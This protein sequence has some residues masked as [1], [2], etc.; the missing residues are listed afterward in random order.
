MNSVNSVIGGIV[1]VG[2]TIASGGLAAPLA[3]GAVGGLIG[4]GKK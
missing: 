2:L 1:G 4:G 3:A